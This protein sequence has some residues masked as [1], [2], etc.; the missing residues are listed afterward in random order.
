MPS[1]WRYEVGTARDDNLFEVVGAI[2]KMQGG[3]KVKTP[4]SPRPKKVEKEVSLSDALK[5]NREIAKEI[6]D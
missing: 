5:A 2:Y 3:K 6:E 4:K 1:S